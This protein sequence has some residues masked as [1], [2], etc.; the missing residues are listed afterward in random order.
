MSFC[1]ENCKL[2]DLAV[3]EARVCIHALRPGCGEGQDATVLL[4]LVLFLGLQVGNAA[5]L[6]STKSC[7]PITNELFL[8]SPYAG[9]NAASVRGLLAD[10]PAL[11]NR[12]SNCGRAAQVQ[13]TLDRHAQEAANSK[14]AIDKETLLWSIY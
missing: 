3:R 14:A 12:V 9:L 8:V 1:V 13:L 11:R 2:E 6:P 7:A 4:N 10:V 5:P